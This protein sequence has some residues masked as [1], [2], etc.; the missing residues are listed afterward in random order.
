VPVLA[1]ALEAM[2]RQGV[3]TSVC[4]SN[5]PFASLSPSDTTL[6][7][8][9]DARFAVVADFVANMGAAYAFGYQMQRNYPAPYQEF[10]R[11][12]GRTVEDTVDETVARA[13]S[14]ERGLMAAALDLGLERI[15]HAG[16]SARNRA[17][18]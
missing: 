3:Q 4:G 15:G 6:Q 8:D 17:D 14:A 11:E 2:E 10:F 5:H 13:G 7:R 16:P 1:K 12:V 18:R 9:A